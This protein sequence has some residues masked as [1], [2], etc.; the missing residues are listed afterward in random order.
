[1]ETIILI[2]V[3]LVVVLLSLLSFLVCLVAIRTMRE[4]SNKSEAHTEKLVTAVMQGAVEG[5]GK[6]AEQ[7]SN[8][9]GETVVK[10]SDA[11][12]RP[13]ER[14][15]DADSRTN[16]ADD[17]T[18]DDNLQFNDWTDSAVGGVPHEKVAGF[19]IGD[20][21]FAVMGI[22]RPNTAGEDFSE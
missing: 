17:T 21:I 5:L 2:F 9:L 19:G 6:V 12:F 14:P 10:V 22:E 18:H 8:N 1:M 13:I 16:N 7:M 4:Q 3:L 15:D 20:D 11:A